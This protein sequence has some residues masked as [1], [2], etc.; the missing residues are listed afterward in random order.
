MEERDTRT[1]PAG[2]LPEEKNVKLYSLAEVAKICEVSR[3]AVYKRLN[4]DNRL[5]TEVDRLTQSDGRRRLF[6]ADAVEVLKQAFSKSGT[7]PASVNQTTTEV[8][9]LTKPVDTE[10]TTKV[11]TLTT[12][13]DRLTQERDH[14][15]QKLEDVTADHAGQL[16]RMQGAFVDELTALTD[17]LNADHRQ[18]LDR[19]REDHRQQLDDMRAQLDQLR[20]D[21]REELDRIQAGHAAEVKRLEKQIDDM[22]AQL[23]TLAQLTQN[24]QTLHAAQLQKEER[25]AIETAAA[26]EEITPQDK[27]PTLWQRIFGKK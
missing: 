4:S 27:P 5:T 16:E 3:Q 9:R 18:E 10:L 15:R 1:A 23:D 20:Q 11:D 19:L 8:D 17:R 6:T 26:P 22:R 2:D 7:A 21:H 25:K 13:V 14:M 24:A 12:E